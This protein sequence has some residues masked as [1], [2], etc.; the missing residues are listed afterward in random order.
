MKR[1]RGGSRG[2]VIG[3]HEWRRKLL[4]LAFLVGAL[5]V[6]G[7]AFQVTVLE[8]GDWARRAETQQGDTIRIPAPRG[9]IYDR[10]GI[11]LASSREVY[12]VAVAR[13]EVSDTPLVTQRL[14][15]LGMSARDVRALFASP[16]RWKQLPG[17]Y[18][19]STRESLKGIDGFHFQATMRRFYPH[20]TLAAEVLGRV[21]LLGEV[22]GGLELEL[23]SILAGRDGLAVKRLDS[24]GRPIPGV[25]L[26]VSEPVPGRDVVLT[27]D[28]E[29]QEIAEDALE[30]ALAETQAEAGEMI[31]VDPHSGDILAAVSRRR[32]RN[33]STWSAATEPYEP[34]S[35]IKA[36]TIASLL[37]EGKATL[38]DSVYGEEGSYRVNG[39]TIT[40]THEVGWVTLR[41]GFL[42]SSNIV[43]AKVASRMRAPEQY[44]RLRD[45]GFGVPTGVGYPSESGG[46]LREP[47]DWSRQSTASLA[48]GYELSVTPLQLAMG[49]AALAN[50]GLLMAPLLVR[51]V[52]GRDGST[53]RSAQPGVVRRVISEE[54]SAAVRTLLGD[55][56]EF[57]TGR[58]ASL[59]RWR[60]AGKT[61]TARVASGGGYVRGAYI[62]TFAGFFPAEDPQIVFLVKV[63][64]PRGDYYASLTAAPVTKATLQAALAAR[65]TP[66]DRSAVAFMTE[67]DDGVEPTTGAIA[68]ATQ[69]VR[70]VY[71]ADEP[72]VLVPAT[73]VRAASRNE[74]AKRDVPDVN[75]AS[76]RDAVRALHAAGFRV[77][78][79]GSG[80]V[81]RTVPAIGTSVR[82]G[83]EV[84][85]RAG[86]GR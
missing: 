25:M 24:Y 63:D 44:S 2:G 13:Q 1:R 11:P 28:T 5:V 74:E 26:R 34:G 31:I 47:P 71:T 48:F 6:L 32:G 61:G 19:E 75:G 78:V 69:V 56:V 16:R 81:E 42:E 10:D 86:S 4:L 52:R 50:G 68:A 77:R 9:T 53:Q 55:A 57:G 60:V 21:N 66:L 39:R 64:R 70:A 85:V 20:A 65:G 30:E 23:D 35:T 18:E 36:F 7:R 8:H 49:Y 41:E 76:L 73:S 79:E 80:R 59:G 29:L 54:V 3:R 51:E 22:A 62:A 58:S 72:V 46:L 37:M 84:V 67:A 15:E 83:T 40:D 12:I 43:M 33:A 45:F 17:R 14:R 27:L 82:I 38:E